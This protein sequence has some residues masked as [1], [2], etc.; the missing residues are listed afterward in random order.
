VT[1]TP[2]QTSQ[3][4]ED[5]RK[6]LEFIQVVI[7]RLSNSAANAKGWSVTVGGAA[8]GF[9]TLNERWYIAILG[10]FV[11]VG[12]TLSLTCIIYSK[13]VFF[14]GCMMMCARAL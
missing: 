7:S 6:H 8:F 4:A 3:E 5:R 1:S 2:G 12:L 14:G 10:L 9:S 13:S 11:I